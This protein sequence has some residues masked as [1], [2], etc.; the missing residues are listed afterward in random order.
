MKYQES[1]S[2]NNGNT[3]CSL[4]GNY[5]DK[6]KN[7]KIKFF[8]VSDSEAAASIES[9]GLDELFYIRFHDDLHCVT[10]LNMADITRLLSHKKESL[11]VE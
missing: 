7:R 5:T 10:D 9:F 4:H 6:G 3:I 2:N 1:M 11:I 8:L